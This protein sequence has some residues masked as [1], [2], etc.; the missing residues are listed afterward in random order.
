MTRRCVTA[1]TLARIRKVTNSL[2]RRVNVPS[3]RV[4]LASVPC[5]TQEMCGMLISG[6]GEASFQ[7]IESVNAARIDRQFG[8]HARRLKPHMHE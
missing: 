7:E 4:G 2:M 3:R 1:R 8:R 6:T 5:G